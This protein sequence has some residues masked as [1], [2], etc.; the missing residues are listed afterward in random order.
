M[1]IQS[2][3]TFNISLL[4]ASGHFADFLIRHHSPVLSVRRMMTAIGLLGPGVF[5]FCF[6]FVRHLP[7]AV[8]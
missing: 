2:I 7:L 8:M 1:Y 4:V 3:L 6:S 5:I